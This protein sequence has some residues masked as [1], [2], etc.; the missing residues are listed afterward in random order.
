MSKQNF[1][2]SLWIERFVKSMARDV[3]EQKNEIDKQMAEE[4]EKNAKQPFLD[5]NKRQL[6]ILK[7]LQTIPTVKREDYCAM[8]DVST[9]TAYRDLDDLVNKK[10]I[11]VEGR[12][13][14][15]KYMLV[16]R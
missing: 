16:S 14:G 10:L 5:L 6:K 11:K 13:R 1:E 7:Y 4:Q 2:S 12:G 8:M 9:M 3:E 15:T